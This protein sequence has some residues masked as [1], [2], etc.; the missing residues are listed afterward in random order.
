MDA[1]EGVTVVD[2]TSH[3][4]GP[5]A[6]KLM[7]DLGARVIKVERPDGDLSRQLGPFL[8]DVPGVERSAT[9]QFLNT[10]KESVVA[11]LGSDSGRRLLAR[12]VETADLVVESFPPAVAERLGVDYPTLKAIADV[13]VVSITNFGQEGPYRDYTLSDTVLYAMGGE[14]WSLGIAGEP[15]LKPGGTST[16]LQ[17]GAIAAVAALGGIHAWELHGIGQHIDVPLFEVQIQS[18][19]RRSSA[20]LAYRF[21]GRVHEAPPTPNAAPAGGVYPCADGFVEVTATPGTYWPRLV[22]MIGQEEFAAGDEWTDA[23]FLKSPDGRAAADAVIYP[24]MLARTRDEIW[25]EARR[26]HALVAPLWTN[27]DLLRDPVLR[28]RGFWTEVEHEILGRL[29]MIGRPY[30][31]E[32]TPWRI[33]RPAPRLGEHT[34]AVMAELG[35]LDES[36]AVSRDGGLQ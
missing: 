29:P 27:M 8:D 16:L 12:L 34:E 10:N 6:T 25:R 22:A 4:A 14:M 5:Y 2:L 23:D 30:V 21:S 19:D 28:E 33:R 17:C 32:K 15:P 35:L 31:L 1:L 7:A 20:I 26:A 11:D 18:V 9:Y 13:P 24:W 36:A 3:I